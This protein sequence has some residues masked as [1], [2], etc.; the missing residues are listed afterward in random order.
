MKDHKLL[1]TSITM[2]YIKFAIFSVSF[3]IVCGLAACFMIG[4]WVQRYHEDEDKKGMEFKDLK[5]SLDMPYP[6]LS[7]C[8]TNPFL[9]EEF[10]NHPS[11]VNM[12]DYRQYIRG[13]G[14]FHENFNKI[15]Y[16]EVTL[17]ILE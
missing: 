13:D 3:K 16:S 4:Y 14:T 12:E 7:I 15:N 5:S 9:P 11:N 8:I 10:K 2:T 17:N 6:E 1:M